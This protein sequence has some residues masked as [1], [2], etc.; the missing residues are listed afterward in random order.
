MCGIHLGPRRERTVAHTP[1][2]L[3]ER[4]AT[5]FREMPGLCLTLA[6]AA[7]L[8]GTAPAPCARAL[9]TLV[10]AGVLCQDEG[11][12]RPSEADAHARD[13]ALRVITRERNGSWIY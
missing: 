6:Q 9:E 8:F 5:E 13:R 12:Y 4:I 7:R 10:R 3:E 2:D 1:L 11:L